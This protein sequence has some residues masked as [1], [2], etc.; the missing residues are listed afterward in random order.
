MSNEELV[1]LEKGIGELFVEPDA[2]GARE[3]FKKKPRKKV[4]KVTT[5]KKAVE[6]FIEDGTY[7]GVGGFGTN[8]IPTAVYHEIVRQK[9]KNIGLSGHTATHDGQI[10]MAGKVVDR[11]D[12]AYVVGLEAR[13]LSKSARDAF[14]KYGIKVTEWSNA[15]LAWRYK[16]AAMGLPFLPTRVL[17][18]TD[19]FKY[20]G[21][22][23]MNCPFT[24]QKLAAL[25]ALNVDV[26]VIHVHKADIYGNCQ[27]EGIEVSDTDLVKCAKR[28]IV[29]TE[30]LVPHSQMR[31]E[32]DKVKIPYFLVDAVAEVP[33]GCYPGN[34][35]YRY[36]S[37]EEHLKLWLEKESKGEIESFIEEYI[38]NT[39]DFEE[40]LELCGGIKRIKE[41]RRQENLIEDLE[42]LEG[43]DQ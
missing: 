35:A 27:I 34:M 5:V 30:E 25:P 2:D 28:V 24:G 33:F 39:K 1:N 4:P 21:A 18:G 9:K 41:L 26:A 3:Y 22:K 38:H 10:L 32:T 8:R 11:C 13:G 40:Y 17:L 29:T 31:N 15:A 42:E 16:A 43:L 14:E 6:E 12:A 19:T 20:S 36:F 23:V 37:D 7:L